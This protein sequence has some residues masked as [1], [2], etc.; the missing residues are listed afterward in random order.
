[1]ISDDQTSWDER[2]EAH[3]R[4]AELALR[5]LVEAIDP[6][7]KAE[8]NEVLDNRGPLALDV[9]RQVN[10]TMTQLQELAVDAIEAAMRAGE[11]QRATA[12]A[13]GVP[14]DA[15]AGAKAQFGGPR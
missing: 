14:A 4:R 13:L 2:M 9:C 10:A 7:V 15:L 1:M 5:E 12:E 11:T 6:L 3:G 8:R